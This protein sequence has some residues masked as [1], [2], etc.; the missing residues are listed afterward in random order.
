MSGVKVTW[1]QPDGTEKTVESSEIGQSLMEIARQN[2]VEG[3]MGDCNGG[4]D[5]GTCHCHIPEEWRATVGPASE[6]ELTTLDLAS[7]F[8]PEQSRLTCQIKLAP[9]LDGLKLIVA[10]F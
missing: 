7:N 9:E 10:T 5:C 2:G 1:V 6:V 8:D 4:A 3:I